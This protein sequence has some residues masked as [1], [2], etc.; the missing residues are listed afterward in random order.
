MGLSHSNMRIWFGGEGKFNVLSF[1]DGDLLELLL[2]FEGLNLGLLDLLV[3]KYCV[4]FLFA[5][6]DL[7]V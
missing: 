3:C 2:K 6:L 7:E 1:T 5:L 4:I